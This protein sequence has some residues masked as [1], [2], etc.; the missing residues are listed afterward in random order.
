M[1]N[2]Y[3]LLIMSCISFAAF[4][5]SSTFTYNGSVQ[6]FTVPICATQVSV[7]VR[8]AKGGNYPGESV[9][10]SGGRVQCTVNVTGGEVLYVYVG[11][12]GANGTGGAPLP[13]GGLNSGGGADGGAGSTSDGGAAGGAASDIRTI[14]GNSSAALSSRLVAA[15]GGGGRL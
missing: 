6:T 10:G 8:G 11:Q 13:A 2:L 4:A 15:G 7:D 3:S 14:A 5:Q 1:K 12:L 9:G